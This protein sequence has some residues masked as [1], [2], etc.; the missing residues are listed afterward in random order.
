MMRRKDLQNLKN[1]GD[2]RERKKIV[3]FS[4]LFDYIELLY[5]HKGQNA[6][7][8]FGWKMTSSPCGAVPVD[9]LS[10]YVDVSTY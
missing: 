7:L 5:G 1:S 9:F 8:C 2:D 3:H 10:P 4:G 6:S